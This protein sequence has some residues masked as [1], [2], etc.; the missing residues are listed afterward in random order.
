MSLDA[1]CCYPAIWYVVVIHPVRDPT[2]WRIHYIRD[3]ASSGVVV[4]YQ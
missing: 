1:G 4:C 3:V 2:M